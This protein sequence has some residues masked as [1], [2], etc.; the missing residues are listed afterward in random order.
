MDFKLWDLLSPFIFWYNNQQNLLLLKHAGEWR[1]IQQGFK[2]YSTWIWKGSSLLQRVRSKF[3]RIT[4][5]HYYESKISKTLF[6]GK[7]WKIHIPY[8]NILFCFY[9]HVSIWATPLL[10]FTFCLPFSWRSY[11]QKWVLKKQKIE[12]AVT[13]LEQGNSENSSHLVGAGNVETLHP[14]HTAEEVPDKIFTV[15]EKILSCIVSLL[16]WMWANEINNLNL[17]SD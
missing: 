9:N 5:M 15:W 17:P 2:L 8:L 13:S 16:W 10:F 4:W 1:I 11:I 6:D 14:T 12:K 3:W 7:L